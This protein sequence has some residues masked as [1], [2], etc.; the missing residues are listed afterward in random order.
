MEIAMLRAAAAYVRR[1]RRHGQWGCVGTAVSYETLAA[2]ISRAQFL[3]ELKSNDL[4]PSAKLFLMIDQIP[5]A[6][7]ARPLAEMVRCLEC[8]SVVPL[9]QLPSAR[10]LD[11]LAQ[12]IG[13]AGYG[14]ALRGD[15][16][17]DLT[18]LLAEIVTRFAADRRAFTWLGRLDRPE[19]VEAAANAGVRFATGMALQTGPFEALGDVPILPLKQPDGV[20]RELGSTKQPR[21]V[22]R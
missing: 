2:P 16:G 14:L 21:S 12:P 9:I 7:P 10:V 11:R 18:Q 5:M 19:M 6:A 1:I 17:R 3:H 4:G 13:A 15:E 8:P 22:R 20:V